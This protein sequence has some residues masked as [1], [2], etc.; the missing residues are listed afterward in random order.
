M[1]EPFCSWP[2]IRCKQPFSE[3]MCDPM[4]CRGCG[5]D[6]WFVMTPRGKKMPVNKDGS[7]HHSTCPDADDFRYERGVSRDG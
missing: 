1:T 3:C 5:A 4:T 6:M 2:C 7:P